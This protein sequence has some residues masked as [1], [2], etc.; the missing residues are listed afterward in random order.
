MCGYI[1]QMKQG[2][3]LIQRKLVKSMKTLADFA[4]QVRSIDNER[5]R[6]LSQT[7]DRVITC[8]TPQYK[9]MPT[10]GFTHFQPAQLVTVGKRAAL[11]LQDLW[12]DFQKLEDVIET[13]PLRGVKGTTGTQASFLDLFEGD[14][15]KV[16]KLNELV[17]EQMGFKKVIPLS[18]QTYSRKI[19]YFV[20]SVLSGIAQSAYKM[21]GAIRGVVRS[22]STVHMAGDVN[23]YMDG[24]LVL[25]LRQATSVSSR[26]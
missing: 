8:Q 3:Q 20:L 9:D 15:S 23:G 26:T 5:R 19:D 21:A 12:L 6:L 7:D 16:K 18:G 10:M 13:L 14:H 2:L 22:F 25:V 11:W 1:L 17:A 24:Y 4:L